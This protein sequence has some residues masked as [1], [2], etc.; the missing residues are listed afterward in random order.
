MS[1]TASLNVPLTPEL[2]LAIETGVKEGLKILMGKED[3]RDK[4][5]PDQV[6][7]GLV[8]NLT[9]EVGELQI[10]H[11]TD[12]APTCSIPMLPVLGLLVK[13]MGFQ[14]D[15]ALTLLREVMTE[16][17]TMDK[18]AAE[19]IL[20]EEGVEEAEQAVKNEVIARLPRTRVAKAI[21]AKGATLTVTGVVQRPSNAV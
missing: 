5:A 15:K 17:L 8:V 10:G 3:P 11:D 19:A 16:A 21:K 20:I 13:R 14:R 9:L 18:K 2:A 1:S 4:V 6:M 12:R 7:K